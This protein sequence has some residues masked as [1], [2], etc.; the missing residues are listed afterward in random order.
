MSNNDSFIEEVSDEIKRDRM[1]GLL[2]KYGWIGIVAIFLLVG[3][4]AF[5]EYRKAQQTQA[6]QATGDAIIAAFEVETPDER[7]TALSAID[8][9]SDAVVIAQL[10]LADSQIGT[11]DTDGAISTYDAIRNNDDLPAIYRDLATFKSLLLQGDAVD[12]DRRRSAFATLSAPGSAFRLLAEEQ[13]ALIE[14]ET[15]E[16]DQALLRLQRILTDSDIT[17]G[18]QRRVSQLIVSLGGELEAT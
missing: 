11:G 16:P 7:I 15:G 8:T 13:L 10:I 1:F 14:I 2:R 17:S 4:A 6:A 5:N 3:G 18:L 9:N 12:L